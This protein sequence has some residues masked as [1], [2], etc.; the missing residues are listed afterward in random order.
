M[1]KQFSIPQEEGCENYFSFFEDEII[2]IEPEDKETSKNSCIEKIFENKN[3]EATFNEQN[4]EIN[5][6]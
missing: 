3:F 1:P 4:F 2:D 5:E 6:K